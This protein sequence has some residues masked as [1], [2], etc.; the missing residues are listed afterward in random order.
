MPLLKGGVAAQ[1]GLGVMTGVGHFSVVPHYAFYEKRRRLNPLVFEAITGLAFSAGVGSAG[2]KGTATASKLAS[3]LVSDS[4]SRIAQDGTI[5][6][7]I[8]CQ[9]HAAI[10]I[11][12]PFKK[13]L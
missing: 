3:L 13:N 7:G 6:S 10:E 4:Q 8:L 1:V 9:N 2:A 11:S 5:G 12:L